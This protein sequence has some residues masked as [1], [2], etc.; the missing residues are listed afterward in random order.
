M[1]GDNPTERVDDEASRQDERRKRSGCTQGGS[2][3]LV[4]NKKFALLKKAPL[5]FIVY[6]LN[7]VM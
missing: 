5:N 4:W 6:R 1:H 7:H 3:S 2:Y